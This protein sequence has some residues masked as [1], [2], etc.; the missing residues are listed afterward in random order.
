MLDTLSEDQR[1]LLLGSQ[2]LAGSAFHKQLVNQ[3]S[4][5][6]TVS[7]ADSYYTFD[8]Y[9]HPN[10]LDRILSTYQPT[11]VINCIANTNLSDCES[12][13]SRAFYLNSDMIMQ[14]VDYAIPAGAY[15]LH[16]STDAVYD[17]TADS[18]HTESSNLAPSNTYGVSK[19]HG[20]AIALSYEN[21]LILRTNIT[22]F[23][24]SGKSPTFLQWLLAS[25][26]S[27]QTVNLYT[28][29]T[30]STL[31]VNTF[32]DVAIQLLVSGTVGIFNIGSSSASSKYEFGLELARQ[33]GINPSLI[34]PSSGASQFPSRMG[35]LALC[36]DNIQSLISLELPDLRQT[37]SALINTPT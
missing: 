13:P 21:S 19:L 10:Q 34:V 24:K 27:N 15:L 6:R 23:R 31:D 18:P 4:A 22:G 36:S 8:V 11:H 37:I 2:G 26:S 16:V 20:E 30:T 17:S 12:H 32:V 33:L 14:L 35:N 5:L 29:Y 9:K 1:I 25:L 28:D 3:P 7:R